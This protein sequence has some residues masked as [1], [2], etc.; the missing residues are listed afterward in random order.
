MHIYLD[1]VHGRFCAVMA[2]LGGC[3]GDGMARKTQSIYCL[4]FCQPLIRRTNEMHSGVQQSPRA[5]RPRSLSSL[6]WQATV[7]LAFY[8][9]LQSSYQLAGIL[10]TES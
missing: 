1:I 4:A 9:P 2:V 8:Q 3:H 10:R 5:A 7:F 6:Q